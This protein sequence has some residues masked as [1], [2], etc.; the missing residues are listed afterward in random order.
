MPQITSWLKNC[1]KV[2]LHAHLFASI[3][4]KQL[5]NLLIKKNLIEDSKS[6]EDLSNKLDVDLIFQKA[7]SYLPKI[8]RTLSD[9]SHILDL[10]IQ[11][12]IDDNVLYL[13]IRSTPKN[14]EDSDWP[15]W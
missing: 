13:E 10:V 9:L 11:N 14:L 4:Q 3:T 5:H 2:E 8:T 7:F 1:P 15:K 12:F 6:F